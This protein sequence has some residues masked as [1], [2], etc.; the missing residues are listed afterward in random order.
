M[1]G[2]GERSASKHAL[3][4]SS[5]QKLSGAVR[6]ADVGL[7]E[8]EP[9]PWKRTLCRALTLNPQHLQGTFNCL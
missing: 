6:E 9:V 1:I 8:V 5:S 3:S 2:P 7:T 4:P